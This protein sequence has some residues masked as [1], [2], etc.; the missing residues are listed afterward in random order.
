MN[1][2]KPLTRNLILMMQSGVFDDVLNCHGGGVAMAEFTVTRRSRV[3]VRRNTMSL[4]EQEHEHIRQCVKGRWRSFRPIR[5][6][7]TQILI[8]R[9]TGQVLRRSS[10][11]SRK[12]KLTV[13]CEA[14]KAGLPTQSRPGFLL[15]SSWSGAACN[16]L[17]WKKIW[18][19]GTG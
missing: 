8:D 9:M 1:R 6:A 4:S 7:A 12:T 14:G 16:G 19:S 5:L 13:P 11:V 17:S 2:T 10:D 18:H 3:H 15:L